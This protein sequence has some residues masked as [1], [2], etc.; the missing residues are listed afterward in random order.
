MD[1]LASGYRFPYNVIEFF[2]RDIPRLWFILRHGFDFCDTWSMDRAL[3]KWLIPRLRHLSKNLNGVPPRYGLTEEEIRQM[4]DN[5][6]DWDYEPQFERWRSDI[7]KAADQ[8]QEWLD[9]CGTKVDDTWTWEKE[10]E[11]WNRA[12]ESFTWVAKNIGGL[13]N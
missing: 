1:M 7:N 10:L 11:A 13:W 12:E 2:R 4:D 5:P 9:M 8:L 6:C 3:A